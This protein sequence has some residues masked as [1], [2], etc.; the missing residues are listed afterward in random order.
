[1]HMR[2]PCVAGSTT[3]VSYR[4]SARVHEKPENVQMVARATQFLFYHRWSLQG[5]PLRVV[6]STHA[7]ETHSAFS[8]VGEL[9]LDRPIPLPCITR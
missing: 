5:C 7:L 8:A 1:M 3:E 6:V 4:C 2:S 9:V